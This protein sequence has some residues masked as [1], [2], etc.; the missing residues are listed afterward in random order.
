MP[1]RGNIVQKW[2]RASREMS[3]SQSS[4]A[5]AK[6]KD[7]LMTLWDALFR[8]KETNLGKRLFLQLM[9]LLVHIILRQRVQFP[10]LR[11]RLSRI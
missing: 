1:A 11:P 10:R 3:A 2:S 5:Q 9:P 6:D 4:T 7:K 8:A